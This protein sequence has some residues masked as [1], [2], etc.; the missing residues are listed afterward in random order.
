MRFCQERRYGTLRHEIGT[1]RQVRAAVGLAR[2]CLIVRS[3]GG[4]LFS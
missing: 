2:S 1:R 3:G 4:A